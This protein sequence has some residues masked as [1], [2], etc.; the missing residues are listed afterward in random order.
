VF[1]VRK[2]GLVVMNP[3]E[4]QNRTMVVILMMKIKS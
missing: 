1:D 2:K 3:C 4:S